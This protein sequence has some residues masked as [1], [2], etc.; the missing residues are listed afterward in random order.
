MIKYIAP[1]LFLLMLPAL[2]S[3]RWI[4]DVAIIENPA[5]GA[6]GFGHYG[7]LE[8]L[9]NNCVF[10]HNQV[11]N[12]DPVKN[13]PASMT[14]MEK[15]RSCGACHN[16]QKAFSV[17]ENCSSCHPTADIDFS[18]DAGDALFSHALHTELYGCS[19]CH[20]DLFVPDRS[21]RKIRTM[22]QMADGLSCGACHDGDTA[23]S[24]EENCESCHDM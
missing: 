12:I 5:V 1:L 8:A 10:C 11:F 7:H 16:G 21:Q 17:T 2:G 14:D 18:T 13:P 23:F 9:G 22:E 4:D 6:V 19:D 20:P 24:V 3:A 15:G